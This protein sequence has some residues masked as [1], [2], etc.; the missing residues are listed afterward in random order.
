MTKESN[1]YLNYCWS[2]SVLGNFEPVVHVD[3]TM[4]SEVEVRARL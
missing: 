4:G 3:V 2:L 1:C